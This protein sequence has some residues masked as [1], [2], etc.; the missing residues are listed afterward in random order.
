MT[1]RADIVD[2][3][4]SRVG[5]PWQHQ[6]ARDGVACDCI[7]LLILIAKQLLLPGADVFESTTRYR[8]YGREPSPLLL[9]A[10]YEFLDPVELEDAQPG[11]V[12]V[13]RFKREPQHFGIMS[14][15][16]PPYVIHAYAQVRK[17]VE[18]RIDELW[19]SRLVAAFAFRGVE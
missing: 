9:E 1:T 10:C 18:N 15:L 13:M 6:A 11:D 7:G 8:G 4:R 12:L 14:E 17:V 3:A 2:A 5:L 16:D 19:A